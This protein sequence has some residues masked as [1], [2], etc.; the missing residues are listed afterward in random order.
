MAAGFLTLLAGCGDEEDDAKEMD[1][2]TAR[3]KVVM[4]YLDLAEGKGAKVQKGDRVVF[5]YAGWT[6]NGSKLPG[7]YESG[8]PA[9][10]VVGKLD[11]GLIGWHEGMAGMKVG[12]KRKLFIPAE[13][14]FKDQGSPDGRVKANAKV[15]YEIEVLKILADRDDF[16]PDF[17]NY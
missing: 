10:L 5:H 9:S 13:L 14:A 2:T 3:G 12:G 15:I 17:P 7:S 16:D 8:K 11:R 6:H 4:R 1:I